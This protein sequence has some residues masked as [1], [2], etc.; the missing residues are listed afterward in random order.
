MSSSPKL[1]LVRPSEESEQY[2]LQDEDPLSLPSANLIPHNTKERSS[3]HKKTIMKSSAINLCW[4][5]MW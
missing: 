3:E 5:L 4:I 2:S 1:H